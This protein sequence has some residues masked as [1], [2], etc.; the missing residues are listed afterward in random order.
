MY[1]Y[2]YFSII[3]SY[4]YI[5]EGEI[6]R[7]G[8]PARERSS[9]DDMLRT[10][11]GYI[12]ASCFAFRISGVGFRVSGFGLRVSG[13][14]F[15]VSGFEFRVSSF[16]LRISG[17]GLRAS[18]FGFQATDFGL[19]ATG[20]GLRASGFGLQVSGFEFRVLRFGDPAERAQERSAGTAMLKA[21][22]ERTWKS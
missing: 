11:S 19:R 5:G 4:I 7:G 3:I 15:W 18:S 17:F 6:P 8:R 12:A 2:M 22:V 14:G 1:V 9:G 10:T 16:G 13:F 21:A 20:F